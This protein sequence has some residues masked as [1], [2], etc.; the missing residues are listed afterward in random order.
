MM[1]IA[2]VRVRATTCHLLSKHMRQLADAIVAQLVSTCALLLLPDAISASTCVSV[3]LRSSPMCTSEHERM[4]YEMRTFMTASTATSNYKD[5][6]DSRLFSM[7]CLRRREAVGTLN[8]DKRCHAQVLHEA[9][10]RLVQTTPRRVKN[11]R[12]NEK[13]KDVNSP[14][15]HH[16]VSNLVICS[17][18][19]TESTERRFEQ[20]SVRLLHDVCSAHANSHPHC[21]ILLI[22][23]H[24]N[25]QE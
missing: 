6:A 9:C 13:M 7:S 23:V 21:R 3:R 18:A 14:T 15:I 20:R 10:N 5:A 1:Y 8:H 12:P 11:L 16:M 4:N 22:D 17:Q 2:A 25:V 19:L 24:K